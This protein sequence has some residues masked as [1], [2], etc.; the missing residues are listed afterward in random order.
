[1]KI[2]DPGQLLH[3]DS[4]DALA[5]IYWTT[6]YRRRCRLWIFIAFLLGFAR[7]LCMA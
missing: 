1:M 6:R 2:S 3:R 7:L 4:L 5:E